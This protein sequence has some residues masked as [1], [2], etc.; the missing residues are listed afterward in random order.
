MCIYALL[1]HY[2]SSYVY[3]IYENECPASVFLI[4]LLF[5]LFNACKLQNYNKLSSERSVYTKISLK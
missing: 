4:I 3:I 5:I 1:P 2:I